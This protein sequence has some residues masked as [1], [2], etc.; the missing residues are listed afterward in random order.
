VNDV[1]RGS[2]GRF[3]PGNP[4]GGRNLG[5]P[6]ALA[7]YIK[8][9]VLDAWNELLPSGQRRGPAALR[10]LPPKEFIEAAS[11]ICPKELFM[12]VQAEPSPLSDI[13]PDMKRQIAQR[14]LEQLEAE[15]MKTIDA[16]LL[17]EHVGN[18]EKPL[19]D[20]NNPTAEK[21]R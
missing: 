21:S 7:E 15:K 12:A 8:K 9:D 1:I 19:Q 3:L 2:N 16:A 20:S 10:Q 18:D 6:H 13:S 14:I 11:R 4:G 5:S 17:S